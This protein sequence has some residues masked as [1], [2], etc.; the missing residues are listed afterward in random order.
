MSD[1]KS[2]ATPQNDHLGRSNANYVPSGAISLPAV[3]SLKQLKKKKNN[4]GLPDNLKSG[5]ESLSGMNLDHVKVHYNSA[6]PMQLNAHA[7]AQGSNIYLGPGQ[8]KHLPHETWHVV[9]QAQGRVKPTMQMKG[10]VAVNDDLG[11]EREADVMGA[12]AMANAVQGKWEQVNQNVNHNH[13]YTASGPVQL[14]TTARTASADKKDQLATARTAE[15]K[16]GWTHLTHNVAV[17]DGAAARHGISDQ[18][19]HS[20]AKVFI[21]ELAANNVA[22]AVS[23]LTERPPC[24]TAAG[25]GCADYFA[26]YEV[27]HAGWTF[28]FKYLVN[29]GSPTSAEKQL[30]DTY[31]VAARN[32]R[33]AQSDAGDAAV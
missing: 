26:K 23:M 8:E 25:T 4:S 33:I 19:S 2:V 17:I 31:R 29:D 13:S 15:A 22:H 5:V 7:Y 24:T 1:S 3:S 12:R 14:I 11:L 10:K 30:Y 28:D 9:Q 6:Q 18:A 21:A 27:D 32:P 16:Y 20:E